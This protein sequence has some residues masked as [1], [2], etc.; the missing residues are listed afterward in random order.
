MAACHRQ[1]QNAVGGQ[2]SPRTSLTAIVR[3]QT[4][5]RQPRAGHSWRAPFGEL[6]CAAILKRDL[7]GWRKRSHHSCADHSRGRWSER[8]RTRRSGARRSPGPSKPIIYSADNRRPCCQSWRLSVRPCS[9]SPPV[10]AYTPAAIRAPVAVGQLARMPCS[11]RRASSQA[12]PIVMA[13]IA[14]NGPTA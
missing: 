1:R 14:S 4:E 12:E 7:V 13:G 3:T 6:P 11:K 9:R 2:P 10:S 8:V 5:G